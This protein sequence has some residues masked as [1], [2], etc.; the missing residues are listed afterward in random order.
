MTEWH[1][2]ES[3]AISV[4]LHALMLKTYT[5]TIHL[6]QL[7]QLC[8]LDTQVHAPVPTNVNLGFYNTPTYNCMHL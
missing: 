3:I 1:H 2:R 4:L 7:T 8:S 5:N 6:L